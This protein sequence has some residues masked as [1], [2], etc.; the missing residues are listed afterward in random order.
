[1]M[2]VG[3]CCNDKS[4]LSKSCENHIMINS[5]LVLISGPLRIRSVSIS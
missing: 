4:L 3:N 1:M 5:L 2:K